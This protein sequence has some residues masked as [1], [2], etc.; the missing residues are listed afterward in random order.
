MNIFVSYTLRDG[1]LNIS[2][3][4]QI[5]SVLA[6]YGTPYIDI[7]HNNSLTP[8]LY[9]ISMLEKSSVLCAYLTPG[10]LK[11]EWV[12]F[13]LNFA[14]RNAIPIL[15]INTEFFKEPIK[16]NKSRLTNYAI[17]VNMPNQLGLTNR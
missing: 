1:N 4:R 15:W 8:Q 5:E 3:L 2:K 16:N 12:Q 6:K 9:V 13:E 10:F 7:L 17:E 11:S 14:N